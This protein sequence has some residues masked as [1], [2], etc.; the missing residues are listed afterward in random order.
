MDKIQETPE[1]TYL[2]LIRICVSIRITKYNAKMTFVVLAH[3]V[4][5]KEA[6]H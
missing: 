6:A 1:K 4:N 5:Q 3:S 2:K